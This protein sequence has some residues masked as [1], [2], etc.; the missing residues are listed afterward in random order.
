[1]PAKVKMCA[2][3]TLKK[4]ETA[5]FVSPVTPRMIKWNCGTRGMPPPSFMVSKTF[6]FESLQP[7]Q[8]SS[9]CHPCPRCI[10]S[11]N[12]MSL[13]IVPVYKWRLQGKIS[14]HHKE[15]RNSLHGKR[16][17]QGLNILLILHGLYP[18]WPGK[19]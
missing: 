17:V 19:I 13:P 2:W 3:L 1:M 4:F 11:Q 6:K 15:F 7:K 18:L 14:K 5:K 16:K 8:A 9:N 10:H 12:L